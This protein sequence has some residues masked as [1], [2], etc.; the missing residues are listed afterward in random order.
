MKPPNSKLENC[1]KVFIDKIIDN[2]HKCLIIRS[3]Y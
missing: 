2:N 3:S 1:E